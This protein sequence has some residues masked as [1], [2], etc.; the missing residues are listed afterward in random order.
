MSYPYRLISEDGTTLARGV[1]EA[2][3]E[4]RRKDEMSLSKGFVMRYDA[5]IEKNK[6]N[7]ANYDEYAKQMLK[8]GLRPSTIEELEKKIQISESFKRTNEKRLRKF[9][10]AEIVKEKERINPYKLFLML[11]KKD[12]R[13]EIELNE[14]HLD[15]YLFS[16]D[17]S[18]TVESIALED[19]E[20]EA[21]KGVI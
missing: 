13:F 7:I 9:E 11:L 17:G 3:L 14:D 12:E 19:E 5:A 4:K 18:T 10:T 8:R 21:L 15:I 2:N 6:E 1:S 20:V 16:M